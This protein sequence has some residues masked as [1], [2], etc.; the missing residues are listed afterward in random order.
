MLTPSNGKK[1]MLLIGQSVVM[2]SVTDNL[3]RD[4]FKGLIIY[5]NDSFYVNIP[6]KIK[7]YFF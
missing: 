3:S 2:Q 5:E 7:V 1:I 6:H 4:I